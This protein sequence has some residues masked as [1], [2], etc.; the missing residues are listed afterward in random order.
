MQLGADGGAVVGL[1]DG[2]PIGDISFGALITLVL[3]M[4]FTGRLVPRRHLDD[5]IEREKAQ[6]AINE[7]NAA[8]LSELGGSLRDLVELGR[9]TDYMLRTIQGGAA[10]HRLR[11]EA[12]P[13]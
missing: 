4:I 13:T 11:Q 3:V 12:N 1:V 10:D 5:S 2:L 9:T 7:R 8:T 6:A